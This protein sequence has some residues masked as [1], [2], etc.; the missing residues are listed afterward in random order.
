MEIE[1]RPLRP[2]DDRSGFRS[3]DEALD[4][5]FHRYAGQ[6]QFRHHIGVTYV[7][8]VGVRIVGFASVSPATVE[9]AVVKRRSVP[10]PVSVLRLARLAIDDAARGA[11]VG[12]AL[13]RHTLRLAVKMDEELG[14]VGV[15]V[16]AK[17]DAVAFYRKLGFV[18]LDVV[19]GT[20]DV[21]PLPTAMFLPLSSVPR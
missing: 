16:D 2:D 10:Y 3:G 13:L 4:V 5:F 15:L 12:K 21:R 1:I 20:I 8:I 7:A 19:E 14:C 11:G 6:N 18:E 17:P 9:A